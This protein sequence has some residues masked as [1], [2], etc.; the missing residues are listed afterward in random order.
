LGVRGTR[1]QGS[2]EN[3][4]IRSLLTCTPH[5][6]LLYYSGDKIEKNEIGGACNAY[7]GV[8]YTGFWWGNQRERYH[9]EDPDVD[10]TSILRRIFRKWD[11]GAWTCLI[12]HSI[13]TNGGHL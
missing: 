12:W 1:Q 10:G 7:G 13:G 9:L 5:P 3:N 4:I 6:I 11:M 2:G 8:M